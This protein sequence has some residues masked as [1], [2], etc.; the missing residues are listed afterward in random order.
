LTVERDATVAPDAAPLKVTLVADLP[1]RAVIVTDTYSSL[2]G[3]LSYCQAGEEQFL[4]VISTTGEKPV[5]TF[6]TKLA[7]CRE[8]LELADPGVEWNAQSSSL[9]IHWLTGPSGNADDRTIVI[10]N[11]GSA[12]VRPK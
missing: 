2:A 11:D 6:V 8:N 7:S 3:G 4:R 9:Q 5:Q 1:A 12:A 10:G